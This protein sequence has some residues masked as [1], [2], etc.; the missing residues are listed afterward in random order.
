[1]SEAEAT[2]GL[3][4]DVTQFL[5][6]AV[7]QLVIFAVYYIL[8]SLFRWRRPDLFLGR[9]TEGTNARSIPDARSV[10][11]WM[12]AIAK[13]DE[14]SL[15]TAGGVD[16]VLHARC[17]TMHFKI[18]LFLSVTSLPLLFVFALGPGDVRAFGF[19]RLAL[20]H[21]LAPPVSSWPMWVAVVMVWANTLF[22]LRVIDKFDEGAH[23]YKLAAAKSTAGLNAY[24]VIVTD[25]PK[26][27]GAGEVRSFFGAIYGADSL[28]DVKMVR[29]Y[30]TVP[31]GTHAVPKL[32]TA[33]ERADYDPAMS[34]ETGEEPTGCAGM[35]AE[36]LSVR[37]AVAA[38]AKALN[39][40]ANADATVAAAAAEG[41]LPETPLDLSHK[42][43]MCEKSDPRVA[44][45]LARER[46]AQLR[47]SLHHALTLLPAESRRTT[48]GSPGLMSKKPSVTRSETD[49]PPSKGKRND[50]AISPAAGTAAIV[51]FDSI[52]TASAAAC[53]IFKASGAPGHGP[54]EAWTVRGMPVPREILWP[55]LESLAPP[56]VRSKTQTAFLI[57]KCLTFMFWSLLVGGIALGV[58]YILT[59]IATVPN[60]TLQT[61]IAIVSGIVP[62]VL[63]NFLL[64]FMST[65][66]RM[67]TLALGGTIT[68]SEANA[69]VQADYGLFLVLIAFFA[70]M[71]ASSLFD[72]AV[73]VGSEPLSIFPLLAAAVPASAYTFMSLVFLKTIGLMNAMTQ[74]TGAIVRVILVKL[75]MIKTKLAM[76]ELDRGPPKGEVVRACWQMWCSSSASSTRRS[77]RSPPSSSQCMR[78]ARASRRGSTLP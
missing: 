5:S 34:E 28:V 4:V 39:I 25:L 57:I 26:G 63:A 53:G 71:L 33:K 58:Q 20:S 3:A 62:V 74:L 44:A 27:V 42:P 47:D 38:Y 67:L 54:T 52:A 36:R 14:E 13:L 7:S 68:E 35:M 48:D 78:A 49:S 12:R 51:T 66:L 50:E 10:F 18:A 41:K 40:L 17:A 32:L 70:P 55:N 16:G 31:E 23:E 72:A 15:Y 73:Q 43:G 37:A 9:T 59:I 76:A 60:A 19:A 22:A 56:A 61:V 65:V 6:L 11:G 69:V 29:K 8:F 1:M 30:S 64:V 46:A 75:G 2:P 24:S 77:R 21:V 45:A